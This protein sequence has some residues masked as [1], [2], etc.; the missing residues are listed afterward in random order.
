MEIGDPVKIGSNRVKAGF[1]RRRLQA[2]G[3]IRVMGRISMLCVLGLALCGVAMANIIPTS[4]TVTG[5]GPFDWIY[6]LQ[7]SNDQNVNSGT[8]PTVN[9]VP[10]ANLTFAGFF[11]IYDFAG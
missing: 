4:T 6:D 11:T 3:E 5:T 9:P 7:L 8:A 2:Q 1:G 10:H